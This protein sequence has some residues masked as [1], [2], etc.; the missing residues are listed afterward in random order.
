LN[1]EE[2]IVLAITGNGLK[3]VGA[4]NGQFEDSA[5]IRPR[6]TEFEEQF[7]DLAATQA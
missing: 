6:L 5:S 7:L 4:M 3:T 2:S 1:P